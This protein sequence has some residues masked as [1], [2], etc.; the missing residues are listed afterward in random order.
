MTSYNDLAPQSKV[1]IYQADRFL[2]EE[3]ITI[4]DTAISE[5]VHRWAAH[6]S[7]LKAYGRIYHEKFLVLMVDETQAGASGCSI[8]SSV[9]FVQDIGK[10][11]EI[12]FFKRTE[13]VYV[14]EEGDMQTFQLSKIKE[15]YKE[16]K[17]TADSRVFNN[18][19]KTKEEFETQWLIPL[20]ET[21]MKNRIG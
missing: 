2:E 7:N 20:K 9:H 6:G 1:W 14:Q 15:E 12:D 21:W 16:G 11:L 4:L 17:L 10:T 18:L 13:M 3:E 5:F 8:D 19:I